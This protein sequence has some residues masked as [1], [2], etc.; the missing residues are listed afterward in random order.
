MIGEKVGHARL[1]LEPWR[2]LQ[3]L[4]T[5][6]QND[7]DS[8][9]LVLRLR[10]PPASDG[11]L[12]GLGNLMKDYNPLQ[13]NAAL[14]A[15][16]SPACAVWGPPCT[17]KTRTA[18]LGTALVLTMNQPALCIAP[19]DTAV[20][21]LARSVAF[22]LEAQAPS[23]P[24]R[25]IRYGLPVQPKVRGHAFISPRAHVERLRPGLLAE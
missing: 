20:D 7:H 15:V 25:V 23:S 8:G 16:A 19:I 6:L 17:G 4:V 10:Q 22:L 9:K 12:I 11:A 3:A 14:Q 21:H 5:V 18:P 2:V 24:T 1:T 13:V